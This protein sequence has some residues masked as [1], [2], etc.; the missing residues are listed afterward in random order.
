MSLMLLGILNSQAAGGGGVPAYDLLETTTL[1]STT[2]SITF[3]GLGSYS[4]YAHLQIRAVHRD[5]R[6]SLHSAIA[7]MRFN[8]ESSNYSFHRL[9]GNGSSVSSGFANYAGIYMGL[10]S[11]N[12]TVSGN[13]ASTTCDIL[14]AFSSTKNTT[15][16][17]L[18]GHSLGSVLLLSSLWRVTDP[19]TSIN[20]FPDDSNSWV[21][22]CRFSLYGIKGA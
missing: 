17:S 6:T 11:T 1:T 21:A 3:S 5:T 7:L 15:V 16:R 2:S 14:D 22:G 10:S 4:D 19:I 9:V 13:F 8:G 12:Q 18:S 20:I